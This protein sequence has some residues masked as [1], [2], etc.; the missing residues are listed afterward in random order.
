MAACVL[1]NRR[2]SS[3]GDRADVEGA[4]VVMVRD[5]RRELLPMGMPVSAGALLCLTPSDALLKEGTDDTEGGAR[6]LVVPMPRPP[7]LPTLL[8]PFLMVAGADVEALILKLV[9]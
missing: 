6:V 8:T 5:D 1:P 2:P 4:C 9:L 3:R 7:M